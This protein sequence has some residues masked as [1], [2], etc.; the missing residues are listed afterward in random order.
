[1]SDPRAELEPPETSRKHGATL[2]RTVA[3]TIAGVARADAGD[4]DDGM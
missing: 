3:R 1:M 2:R 4:F